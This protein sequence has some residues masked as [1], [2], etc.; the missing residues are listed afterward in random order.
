[1]NDELRGLAAMVEAICLHHGLLQWVDCWAVGRNEGGRYVS[2]FHTRA[3]FRLC[4]V[5]EE[6]FGRLP[7]FIRDNIP[8]DA[9]DI[10]T[11]RARVEKQGLLQHCTPFLIT[12]WKMN[13][14]DDQ[15]KWR[16]GRVVRVVRQKSQ[17]P[18]PD[19]PATPGR[20]R[21]ENLAQALDWAVERRAYADREEARAAYL[22]IKERL[23]PQSAAQMYGAWEAHVAGL[24]H[25]RK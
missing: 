20:P 24:L 25:Q 7:T 8:D 15:D 3:Q 1:M 23:Q 5:Y 18:A 9:G 6:Q 21:F 22:E 4:A 12:R 17:A 10:S 19:V 13:P 2:L 14:A 11:E 16:F